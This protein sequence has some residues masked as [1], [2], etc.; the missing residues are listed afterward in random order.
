[1][2]YKELLSTNKF[3]CYALSIEMEHCILEP[4][5]INIYR[6]VRNAT[7]TAGANERS[8]CQSSSYCYEVLLDRHI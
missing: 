7:V 2:Q 6:F 3:P 5:M 8:G 4:E 1:M